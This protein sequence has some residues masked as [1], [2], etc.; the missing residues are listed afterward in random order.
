[1]STGEPPTTGG[2]LLIVTYH[3]VRG[4]GGPYPGIH[5]VSR[6]T[7]EQQIERLRRQ[8]HPASPAEVSGFASGNQPLQQDSFL[9][10]FD[11]GLQDHHTGARSVLNNM[12]MV[13]V[14]FVPTRPLLQNLSPAVHKIHWLR[15]NTEPGR[16]NA[17]LSESL[18]DEWSKLELSEVDRERAAKMHIHDIPEVQALKFALNFIIPYNIVDQTTSRMLVTAGLSEADFCSMTFMD[19]SQLRELAAE[20]HMIGLHGH[21]HVPLSSLDSNRML[22]DVNK[23]AAALQEVLGSRPNWLSYPYGRPDALPADPESL[24]KKCG[25]NV[26]FTLISGFNEFGTSAARLKR[27]TPNELNGFLS[28]P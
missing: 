5:P 24:C 10:T 17:M 1:M 22:Q 9:I 7:L 15:A 11:D 28:V 6:D 21:D 2:R 20:G 12:G 3:Y 25:I 19:G 27:I 16:F 26:G 23:N 14:F 18:P 4:H 8:Y 13:G